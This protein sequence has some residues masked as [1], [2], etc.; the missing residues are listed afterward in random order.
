MGVIIIL[1]LVLGFLIG[2]Y[3]A[4]S[5]TGG[6]SLYGPVFESILFLPVN[7]AIGTSL[8]VVFLNSIS[9]THAYFRQKRI[10]FKT[11]LYLAAV[12]CPFNIV[13]SLMTGVVTGSFGKDVMKLIFYGFVLFSGTYMIAKKNNHDPKN[14]ACEGRWIFNQKIVD[15][16]GKVFEYAFS[17]MK[18]VPWAALAGFLSGFLG[19]GGGMVMV[20]A[21][22]FVC[23]MPVHI[24]V[25][26][27]GFMLLFNSLTGS[28]VKFSVGEVDIFVGLLFAA[29]SIFGAQIGAKIA[30]G[31]TSKGLKINISILL[32]VLAVFK[33]IDVFFP[34]DD[35]VLM[36]VVGVTF[37]V[38][39]V[40]VNKKKPNSRENQI[41]KP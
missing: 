29:G 15:K 36:V 25:A 38:T 22:N 27:S 28:I 37:V 18:I 13:G 2:I 14:L 6:G 24:I 4:L 21:F 41:Q 32:I 33:I 20:P 31:S 5:G 35:I 34:V 9:T 30:K 10:D 16:D 3:A 40:I 23:N 17:F 12:S 1:G 39:V 26:T 8:F 7:V 19:I 11:G